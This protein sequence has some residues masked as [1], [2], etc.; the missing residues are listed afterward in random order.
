MNFLKGLTFFPSCNAARGRRVILLGR[1]GKG[2]VWTVL[3]TDRDPGDESQM[4]SPRRSLGLLVAGL[5]L[6]FF[7]TSALILLSSWRS[8]EAL[9]PTDF[10]AVPAMVHYPAPAL[11]LS[12]LNGAVH[13]LTDYRGQVV[14]VNLWATWCPP[15]QAEMPVLQKYYENHRQ[16]GFTVVAIE[17]GEPSSEVRSFVQQYGLTF[18]VLLDPSHK[19]TD[20][21]F[22]TASLPS[23]YVVSRD[24]QV[25]LAWYGAISEANLEKYVTA[26]IREK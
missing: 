18:P 3:F 10:S 13:A 8:E 5:G 11:S 7:G 21:A 2:F 14:L 4:R 6:V 26:L 16:D 22:K 20:Q 1:H 12:D 15:C 19:A 23:S 9:Q 24:G 17:D 25:R